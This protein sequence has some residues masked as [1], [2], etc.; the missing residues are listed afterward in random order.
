MTLPPGFAVRLAPGVRVR[1]H[2]RTLIGGAPIRVNHLSAGARDLMRDG[3]LIVAD[4]ATRRLAEQLL[5]SGMAEPVTALLA[6]IDLDQVTCVIPVRDRPVQLDRLL[7]G[8]DGAMRVIVVD[9]ASID[10]ERM[11]K[12]AGRHGADFI[13]LHRNL[14]PAGAR[15]AGLREV[16]T[17]YVVF[18]DSDVVIDPDAVARLLRH[19]H[20]PRV[21]LVAPR[22][23]GLDRDDSWIGRYE[24]ARSSLDLGR[25]SA[26]VRPHSTIAWVPSA[27]LAARVDAL[28]D[29]F[30]SSMSVGEDVDLVW[31]LD[32]AGWRIRYDADVVARHD[33][34]TSLRSWLRRKAFYGSGA[35][36]LASRHGSKV[37]PAV[38][39]PIGAATAVAVLAQ[40][41][42]S[43]PAVGLLSGVMAWRLSRSLRGGDHPWRTAGELTALGISANLAQLMHLLL[44]HWWPAAFVGAVLSRRVRR[45]LLLAAAVDTMIERRRLEPD[46]DPARFAIA[47]RLDDAAYGAGLWTGAVGVRSVRA[48]LPHIPHSS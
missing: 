46:L 37:A 7:T 11:A 14:G 43:A 21:A 27:V 42:W 1:D 39:T 10:P 33:H 24:A 20:D 29:G 32:A 6:T 47:L 9:D 17:P 12:V 28:G 18:V 40:R 45:A 5:H 34:R 3:T 44:R 8:L 36:P 25:D 15:N 38:L 41:R 30:D 4:A 13:P 35:A 2:G 22:I 26:L 23:R 16:A 19:L 48:L 31:R